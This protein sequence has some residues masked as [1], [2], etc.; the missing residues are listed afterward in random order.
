MILTGIIN[1]GGEPKTEE[2][3]DRYEAIKKALS[4]ARKGDSVVITGMGHEQYRIV[5]GKR[6]PWNDSEVVR[7]I[8]SEKSNKSSSV[9]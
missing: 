9:K 3:P 8:L 6:L 4:V 5:Q 1:G 7:E 2:I